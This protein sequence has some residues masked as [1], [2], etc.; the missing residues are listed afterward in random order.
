[1]WGR[2]RRKE[3]RNVDSWKEINR[4]KLDKGETEKEGNKKRRVG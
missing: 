4:V 1:M 3:E 2:E